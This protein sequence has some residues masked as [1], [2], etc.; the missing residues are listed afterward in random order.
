MSIG[1]RV[2]AALVLSAALWPSCSSSACT[3][4]GCYDQ[5]TLTL[6]S[7]SGAWAPGRYTFIVIAGGQT[8][9]CTAT[10]PDDFPMDGNLLGLTSCSAAAPN[11]QL[12]LWAETV[13]TTTDGPNGRVTTLTPI[14]GDWYFRATIAG[15]P[16][17]ATIMVQRDGTPLLSD[18]VEFDYDEFSPNG[19]EC[20]PTCRQATAQV[21]VPAD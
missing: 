18:R 4:I 20:G 1:W 13:V 10:A 8:G 3:L 14:P 17:N 6:H 2:V 16:S 12:Q 11:F 7:P 9:T 19:A 21:E 15:T 5:A